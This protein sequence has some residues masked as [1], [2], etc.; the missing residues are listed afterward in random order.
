MKF[1][2]LLRRLANFRVAAYDQRGLLFEID[3]KNV[4]TFIQSLRS[5]IYDIGPPGDQKL[6]MCS[7]QSLDR[8]ACII[9]GDL[10]GR[11]LTWSDNYE[12]FFLIDFEH[13]NRGFWG[14]DQLKLACS[15][16][17]ELASDELSVIDTADRGRQDKLRL[18]HI[19]VM[20]CLNYLDR[21][22]DQLYNGNDKSEAAPTITPAFFVENF[23]REILTSA[24][25]HYDLRNEFWILAVCSY[26]LCIQTV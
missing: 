10:N 6:V 1:L 22:A 26:L 21:F 3:Y 11:N 8:I 19:N 20:N 5:I 4:D 7:L 23:V 18:L 2:S 15:I 9:H 12:K 25:M 13:V 14:A 17:S 16:L 24:N